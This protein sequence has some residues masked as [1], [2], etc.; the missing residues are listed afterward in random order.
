VPWSKSVYPGLPIVTR[1]SPALEDIILCEAGALRVLIVRCASPN[2]ECNPLPKW[3]LATAE[4]ALGLCVT[5]LEEEVLCRST[6]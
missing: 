4:A 5:Q 1:G 3:R 2:H 6:T